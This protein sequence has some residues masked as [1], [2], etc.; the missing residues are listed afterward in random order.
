MEDIPYAFVVRSLMYVQTCTRTNITFVVGILG[1]YQ[2]NPRL[3]HWKTA[4][5]VL[6]YLQG[7]KNHMLTYRKYDHLEVN[8]YIDSNF[9]SCMDTRKYAFGFVRGERKTNK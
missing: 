2:S 4:K 9:V 5:K 3:D 8:G 6:L 7:T 1:R